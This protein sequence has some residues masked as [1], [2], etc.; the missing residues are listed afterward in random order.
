M[1]KVVKGQL[2]WVDEILEP[3]KDLIKERYNVMFD[4]DG[5]IQKVVVKG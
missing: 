1:R 4:K 3:L 2:T 5:Y